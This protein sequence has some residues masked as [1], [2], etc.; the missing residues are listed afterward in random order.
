MFLKYSPI[1]II[2]S[3]TIF[4]IPWKSNLVVL[5]YHSEKLKNELKS[6]VE[7]N[8]DV[9]KRKRNYIQFLLP[10]SRKD[11]SKADTLMVRFTKN[12]FNIIS[13]LDYNAPKFSWNVGYV[14]QKSNGHWIGLI[15][16]QNQNKPFIIPLKLK[17][18]RIPK[19]EHSIF[20]YLLPLEFRVGQT[21]DVAI[22]LD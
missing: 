17:R 12:E 18:G 11:K 3:Y 7:R 10:E 20:L 8:T 22:V 6:F 19:G 21:G 5:M 14:E 16:D 15:P 4:L 1:L 13:E 2:I 9:D